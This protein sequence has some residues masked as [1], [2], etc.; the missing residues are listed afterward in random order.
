MGAFARGVLTSR[1]KSLDGLQSLSRELQA[2]LQILQLLP[3]E[4][5]H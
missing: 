1:E 4:F 5:D 2:V 3:L